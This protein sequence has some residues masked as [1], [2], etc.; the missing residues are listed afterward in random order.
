MN[1]TPIVDEIGEEIL[2][3]CAVIPAG[4]ALDTGIQAA[5]S[6]GGGAGIVGAADRVAERR[7]DRVTPG[8]HNGDIYAAVGPTQL[9]F[10][11]M[12]RGLLRKSVGKLL[13]K[14]SRTDV[15]ACSF[16]PSK[17]GASNLSVELSDGT[18]FALQVARVNRSRGQALYDVISSKT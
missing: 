18:V 11:E 13:E 3:A 6:V 8:G 5:G 9:A 1:E 4:L 17:M 10:F 15:A 16:E 12:K 14:T 7:K 2:A